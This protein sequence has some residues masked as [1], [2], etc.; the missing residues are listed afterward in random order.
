MKIF[1]KV[2]NF[3]GAMER[4]VDNAAAGRD[5][6]APPSYVNKR[7]ELCEACELRKGLVCTHND[8]G[9][10]IAAKTRLISEACPLGRWGRVA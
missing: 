9:C 5:V 4:V 2:G 8:C 6:L 7:R 10:V 1:H 3:F